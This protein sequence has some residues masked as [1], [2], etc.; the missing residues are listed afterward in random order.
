MDDLE[1][2]LLRAISRLEALVNKQEDE[3]MPSRLVRC[4]SRLSWHEK[5]A[6]SAV[7]VAGALTK[8]WGM[9]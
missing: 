7:V 6:A 5:T 1:E 3:H 2:R 4:E 9:W 8:A